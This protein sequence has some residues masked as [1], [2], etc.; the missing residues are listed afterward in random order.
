MNGLDLHLLENSG[1]N[2]LH[3]W[4]TGRGGR[5]AFIC[6]LVLY[7]KTFVMWYKHMR[8]KLPP[9]SNV[10]D[11]HSHHVFPSHKSFHVGWAKKIA[12]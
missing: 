8:L 12:L 4:P 3:D 9:N 1:P 2:H 6:C 5:G 11:F 10:V 7:M